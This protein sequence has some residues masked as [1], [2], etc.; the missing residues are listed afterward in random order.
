MRFIDEAEE[1]YQ[2]K[3]QNVSAVLKNL[4]NNLDIN[5]ARRR[6]DIKYSAK[7]SLNNWKL[8]EP[9]QNSQHDWLKG[10]RLN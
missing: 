8:K 1:Q 10:R 2:F 9:K 6:C 7:E 4:G 5:R 3:I